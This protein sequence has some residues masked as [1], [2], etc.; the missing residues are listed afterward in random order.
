LTA[1]TRVVP[2]PRLD[3][4][5]ASVKHFQPDQLLLHDL[6][7]R[8]PPLRR[9][10]GRV[11][12]LARV[13]LRVGVGVAALEQLAGARVAVKMALG[14]AGDAVGE[15]ESR[16]EP[17]RAVGRAHLVQQH[18]RQLVVKRLRVLG[19][20]EVAVL[21]APVPP[22]PRQPVHHLLRRLFRPGDDVPCASRS[23]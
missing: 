17:L 6:P 3:A 21:L 11:E 8:N 15:V 10:D 1:T 5:V 14:R 19:G 4:V 18:V 2:A 23:G 9:R 22:A 16:V 20:V 7:D 13:R 12:R